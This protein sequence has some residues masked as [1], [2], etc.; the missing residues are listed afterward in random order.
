MIHEFSVAEWL[1]YKNNHSFGSQSVQERFKFKWI[2]TATERS[3]E[4]ITRVFIHRRVSLK[5]NLDFGTV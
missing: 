2:N 4:P 5:L 1:Q 3:S